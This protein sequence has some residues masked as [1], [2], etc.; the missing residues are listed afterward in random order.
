MWLERTDAFG[1]GQ[2][3]YRKGRGYKD[4]LA[5]N[6]RIWVLLLEQGFGVGVYCSDVSGAFDQV[7]RNRL[8]F[9]FIYTFNNNHHDQSTHA[10]L[11]LGVF[12]EL[13][14]TR[15]TKCIK[16]LELDGRETIVW[17]KTNPAT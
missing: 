13:K 12:P 4:V 16:A 5:K 17:A 15:N 2:F 9:V 11:R 14:R 10:S 3:A 6:T 8:F 7:A 1:V